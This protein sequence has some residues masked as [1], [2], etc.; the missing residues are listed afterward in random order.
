[1][2]A[3]HDKISKS[4]KDFYEKNPF[5]GFD[6]NK[7]KNKEDLYN[8]ASWYGKLVDSQIPYGKDVIDV[9]C[10][11]GQLAC[12]LALKRRNV[13]GVDFSENS[14]ADAISIKEKFNLENVTFKIANVLDLGL[15]VESF[16]YVFCNGVLH[17]TR[18]PYLGFKNLVKIARKGGFIFVGLYNTYGRLILK[19]RRR[20]VS[21]FL[22]E[23]LKDWVLKKQLGKLE[24]DRDKRET[25][26][27]DQY[28]HP[29]E[30]CHTISEVLGWFEKNG[31]TYVNSIPP[32]KIFKPVSSNEKLFS[33][34][35]KNFFYYNKASYLLVQ[36]AWIFT[37]SA[38]GGYFIIIGQKK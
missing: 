25:W 9:G 28:V 6:L 24:D 10:G 33:K 7:Y 14:I 23:K 3:L 36:L 18:D 29:H 22:N 38:G 12:F 26:Y 11:T 30:S 4:V 27:Q 32:I 34:K 35:R 16:D 5:P 13:V 37:Q 15:P 17:H 8:Q 1:L 31:I 2:E 20:V 21:R 19:L